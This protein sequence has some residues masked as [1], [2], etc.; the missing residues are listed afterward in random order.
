MPFFFEPN[1][2]TNINMKFPRALIRALDEKSG[3]RKKTEAEGE[4]E[5][6]SSAPSY[7]PFGAFLLNKLPMHVQYTRLCD[8]LPAWMRERYLDRD[9][10]RTRTCWATENG[11]QVRGRWGGA[12]G[13]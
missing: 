9:Y 2:D 7:Y 10:G 8:H 12:R 11:I 4:K 5:K 1:L 3:G 13:L 6:E